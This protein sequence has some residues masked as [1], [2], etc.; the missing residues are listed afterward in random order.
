[1]EV[2]TL[3]SDTTVSGSLPHLPR[4]RVRVRVRWVGEGE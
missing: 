4:G 2:G 1:M 3:Y